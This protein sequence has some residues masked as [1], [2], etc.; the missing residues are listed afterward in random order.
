MRYRLL[1]TAILVFSQVVAIKASDRKPWPELAGLVLRQIPDADSSSAI[2]PFTRAGNLIVVKA[3]VDSME[4]NFILDTG[5]PG[6]VLNITYFRDYPVSEQ[7]DASQTSITGTGAAVVKTKVK[8]FSFGNL[9]LY[10]VE[11]DLVSL[12][13]IENTRG[14]RVLGLLGMD[15]FKQCEMIIDYEKNLLYLHRIGRKEASVYKHE[16]LRDTSL[17][18]TIPVEIIDNRIITTTVMGGKKLKFVIDCAA[19]S[20]VLDS[21]LPNKIFENVTITRRV[22]LTGANN[23]RV[24]ALYGDIR[25]LQLGKQDLG[26]LP[27]LITNLEKTCFAH[28]GCVDGV[29]GFDF[30]SLHKVGFNFVNRKM[31]I[32]K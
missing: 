32:W 14:I 11:A 28:A 25:N 20:N 12:G 13:H 10:G 30:L 19:E 26:K 21:R 17:Y 31:Y 23:E 5:A 29:L 27:V 16:M 6:L 1:Y 8:D 3:R 2:I 9:E 18:R 7:H 4:G 15:L 24:D 22:V